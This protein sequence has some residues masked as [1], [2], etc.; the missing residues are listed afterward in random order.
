MPSLG[1][2]TNLLALN[3]V[4]S[5]L[6]K[7]LPAERRERQRPLAV[8][9]VS[10]SVSSICDAH[11]EPLSLPAPRHYLLR[12][13]KIN[14]FRYVQLFSLRLRGVGAGCVCASKDNFQTNKH[15]GNLYTS[16][17]RSCK[18]YDSRESGANERRRRRRKKTRTFNLLLGNP[19][20]API[21]LQRA[22]DCLHGK[23]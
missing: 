1:V 2:L 12:F 14:L 22:C 9:G 23:Q 8:L 3:H 7:K 5:V 21:S 19:N 17:C 20:S 13:S 16:Q 10:P 11:R 18:N 6:P 15:H 4:P